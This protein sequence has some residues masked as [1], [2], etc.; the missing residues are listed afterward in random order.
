M[1]RI[2]N[3]YVILGDSKDY[4]LALDL[5][6]KDKNNQPVYKSLGYYGTVQTALNGLYKHLTKKVV[7][8]K[9]MSLQEAAKEFERIAEDLKQYYKRFA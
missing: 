3:D 7:A 1:I 5:H 6:R 8:E 4:T 2:N 9:I